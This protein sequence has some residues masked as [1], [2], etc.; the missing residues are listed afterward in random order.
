MDSLYKDLLI[1]M[2]NSYQELH[3]LGQEPCSLYKPITYTLQSGGKRLRPILALMAASL[4]SDSD[5]L[6]KIL[7]IAH[8]LETFHNFTLLHDDIMDN[9]LVRRGMPSVCA[10]YGLSQ[11][12]LSGDAMFAIAINDLAKTS[13][14]R[15]PHLL[16][17]FSKMALD[18]MRGQQLDM[19][20][21][22]EKSISLPQYIE[23]IRL[24]TA[25]LFSTALEMGAYAA[26]AS[27]VDCQAIAESG[28]AFGIAFQLRDD[29]LDVYGDNETFGKPIGGDIEENKK[30]WLSIRATEIA[31]KKNDAD[32]DKALSIKD[33]KEKFLAVKAF[34]DKCQLPKEG[35][36]YI[37][38]YTTKALLALD[39]LSPRNNEAKAS[40]HSL[41]LKLAGR[42]L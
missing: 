34:Y 25:V 18:I 17:L 32:L 9:A 2:E 15:T 20:F 10:K 11:A 40:L 5:K 28:L 26:G 36:E 14:D 8:A 3:S 38:Q 29:Y 42:I 21:E 24:K 27:G 30:T 31:L 13:Q 22:T 6:E 33:S 1:K 41:Y 37:Q 19:D 23:M 39:K 35:E 16:S 7:P 4:Y 12:I